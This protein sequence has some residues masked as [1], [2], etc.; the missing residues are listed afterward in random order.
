M[1]RF[2]ENSS[3]Y[4]TI[5]LIRVNGFKDLISISGFLLCLHPAKYRRTRSAK[6]DYISLF[7]K[8]FEY[9]IYLM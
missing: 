7:V 1:Y 4:F 3:I 5:T 9:F 6:L 8:W 2:P